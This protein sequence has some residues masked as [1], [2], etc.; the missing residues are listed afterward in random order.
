MGGWDVYCALCST[1]MGVDDERVPA[2]RDPVMLAIRRRV[3]LA[4]KARVESGEVTR[5]YADFYD[6]G[7]QQLDDSEIH[8]DWDDESCA[9]DPT[10]LGDDDV[11]WQGDVRCFGLNCRTS[12]WV[13]HP[14]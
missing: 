3:M 8:W 9:Y 5:P 4:L 11:Q 2:S 14:G 6:E 1:E 12:R 7:A 10:L 13:G